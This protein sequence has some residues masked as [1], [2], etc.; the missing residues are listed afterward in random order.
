MKPETWPTN[1]TGLTMRRTGSELV[2]RCTLQ[3]AAS[4]RKYYVD[5]G[6]LDSA[7]HGFIKVRY[8][9]WRSLLGRVVLTLSPS[10]NKEDDVQVE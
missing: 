8:S 1:L 6:Y 9:G 10:G 5:R 2:N 3:T 7:S 4:T